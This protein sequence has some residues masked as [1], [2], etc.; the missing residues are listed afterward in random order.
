[1][2]VEI[3]MTLDVG[4]QDSQQNAIKFAQAILLEINKYGGIDELIDMMIFDTNIHPKSM[5]NYLSAISK[6]KQRKIE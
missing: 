4:K 3:K 5:L 2:Y 6:F 1:M